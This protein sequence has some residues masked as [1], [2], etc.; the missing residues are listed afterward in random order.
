MSM[1]CESMQQ[2]HCCRST[3]DS[4]LCMPSSLPPPP[5]THTC[6]APPTPHNNTNN[7]CRATSD[8]GLATHPPFLHHHPL[9]PFTCSP[10]TTTPTAA[11]PHLHQCQPDRS[12]LYGHCGGGLCGADGGVNARGG[13]ARGVCALGGCVEEWGGEGGVGSC[14][15]D[16]G[17]DTRRAGSA[18]GVCAPVCRGA[19]GEWGEGG[20]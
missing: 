11:G 8:V 4:S 20:W 14:G 16:G 12:L 5:H 1:P 10:L 9:F 6:P 17:V 3:A 13:S 19:L 2:P 7:S 18:R 15:A